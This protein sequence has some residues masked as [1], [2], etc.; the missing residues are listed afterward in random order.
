[1]KA[2]PEGEKGRKEETEKSKPRREEE[3][4]LS[5]HVGEV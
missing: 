1:V 3:V 2:L 4:P 5:Y